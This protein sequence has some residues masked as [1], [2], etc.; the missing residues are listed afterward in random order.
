MSSGPALVLRKLQRGPTHLGGFH[1]VL[2]ASRHHR[3]THLYPS[4]PRH[5]TRVLYSYRLRSRWRKA[6]SIVSKAAGSCCGC[7]PVQAAPWKPS[8]HSSQATPPKPGSQL[9]VPLPR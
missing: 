5:M 4:V 8:R 9:Q 3:N 2:P 1:S 7:S 6:I